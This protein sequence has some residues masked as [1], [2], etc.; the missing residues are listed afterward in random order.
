MLSGLVWSPSSRKKKHGPRQASSRLVALALFVSTPQNFAAPFGGRRI[1]RRLRLRLRTS[2]LYLSGRPPLASALMDSI[3]P[4]HSWGPKSR[5]YKYVTPSPS[6][7]GALPRR[8]VPTY[9]RVPKTYKPSRA[10]LRFFYFYIS[11]P[12]PSVISF[13]KTSVLWALSR[14]GTLV[15]SPF[16]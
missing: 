4:P 5:P 10:V 6:T 7:R 8:V 16:N 15:K 3:L 13:T 9:L 12:T 1:P 14:C 2:L 11:N